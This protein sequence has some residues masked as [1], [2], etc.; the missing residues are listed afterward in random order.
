MEY[1]H[2]KPVCLKCVQLVVEPLLLTAEPRHEV[3]DEKPVVLEPRR[4]VGR[5]YRGLVALEVAV[6][7]VF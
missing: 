2:E 6:E 3:V 5:A 4:V 1:S 7:S